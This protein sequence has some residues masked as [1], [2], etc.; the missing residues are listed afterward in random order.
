MMAAAAR[1]SGT[2][3]PL[4]STLYRGRTV[5]AISRAIAT[6]RALASFARRVRER[7]AEYKTRFA[8]VGEA[9]VD[10]VPF[11]TDPLTAASAGVTPVLMRPRSARG[12]IQRYGFLFTGVTQA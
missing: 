8:A 4:A 2:R 11:L 9:T 6:A 1:M 10:V 7:S 3:S 12:P 5:S